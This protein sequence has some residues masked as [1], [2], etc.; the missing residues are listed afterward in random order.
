M[1]D[2]TRAIGT[3]WW[4]P[5]HL[6]PI[7]EVVQGAETNDALVLWMMN[8]LHSLGKTPV[9]VRTDTPGFIGNRLQHA[10]WREAFALLEEGVADAATI[11]L[12]VSQTIGLKLPALGPLENADYVGLD[13][14]LAIHEYV[15]P[16]LS[17]AT[18]PS[19]FLRDAVLQGR[20]GA[21]SGEGLFVWPDGQRERV[22]ERLNK[23]LQRATSKSD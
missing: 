5:P 2:R 8:L 7:V 20:L 12:V 14:I 19:R 6:V 21:K 23:Q 10:L 22:V 16:A 11:D 1:Q 13:L 3:H 18:E 4:N 17:R 9:H 15:F